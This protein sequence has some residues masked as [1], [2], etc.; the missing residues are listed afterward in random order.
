MASHS[1]DPGLF[2]LFFFALF[3]SLPPPSTIHTNTPTHQSAQAW[4][5]PYLCDDA[6]PAGLA[7]AALAACAGGD[8]H[9]G[10]DGDSRGH[11][12]L[13]PWQHL[14]FFLAPTERNAAALLPGATDV[15]LRLEHR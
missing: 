5:L 4:Y 7:G 1:P 8:H 6:I 15:T 13:A 12:D 11:R 10:A 9:G 14:V 3:V 2:F